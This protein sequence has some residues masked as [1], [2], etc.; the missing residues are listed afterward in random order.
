[1]TIKAKPLESHAESIQLE[2]QKG[3]N[4]LKTR[5]ANQ[6]KA[7]QVLKD[8]GGD[9][10][11]VSNLAAALKGFNATDLIAERQSKI[12]KIKSQIADGSYRPSSEN[13]AAALAEEIS[14]EILLS[15]GLSSAEN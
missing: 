11:Q 6:E 8:K 9:T 3:P 4:D 13:V 10:V 2:R 5:Q 12:D 1:M 7:L 15:G 14:S